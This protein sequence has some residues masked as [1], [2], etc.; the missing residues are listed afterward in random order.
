[1]VLRLLDEIGGT[2]VTFTRALR[3]VATIPRQIPRIISYMYEMGYATAPM[4]VVLSFFIGAVLALQTG[5]ALLTFGDVKNSLGAV[6]GLSMTRE[7]G[8]VMAAFLLIGRVGSSITAEIASMKVYQEI[9]ALTV[10]RIPPERML[11]LPRLVSV[12]FVMPM[13][14]ILAIVVG[15]LGGMVVSQSV[16]I[17]DVP[18]EIYWRFLQGTVQTKDILAGLIKA[19][20]F[21]IAIIMIS[22][23]TGLRT[24]G[25]PREVGTSVTR[26]VVL[27]MVFILI[28]DY[29]VTKALT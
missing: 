10:M 7:L 14:T 13:L 4:V 5:Y 18:S 28:A 16:A 9:D 27:S 17:I 8:P 11:V 3:H 23:H 29:F 19:E 22:C 12:C 25:G 20:I 1:M 21:G 6:V 24:E 26:S 15:W 2:V